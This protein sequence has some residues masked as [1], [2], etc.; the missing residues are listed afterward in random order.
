MRTFKD[1]RGTR[2]LLKKLD[3]KS[4]TLLSL[5]LVTTLKKI[6]R[7]E[8]EDPELSSEGAFSQCSGCHSVFFPLSLRPA[9]WQTLS[10]LLF[11][12]RRL[13]EWR[14]G[15]KERKNLFPAFFRQNCTFKVEPGSRAREIWRSHSARGHKR[16]RAF[17]N[18]E[19]KRANL[20]VC[21]V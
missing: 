13:K 4:F 1:E 7:Q 19:T 14:K 15:K 12:L 17:T 20:S 3:M 9:K 21:C 6:S 10:F 5:S 16:E 18:S 11:N 2:N 8:E